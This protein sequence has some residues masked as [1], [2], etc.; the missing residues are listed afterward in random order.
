MGTRLSVTGA[1]VGSI[2]SKTNYQMAAPLPPNP[3][4]FLFSSVCV[5]YSYRATNNNIYPLDF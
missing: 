1:N 2:G 5:F 4:A 3:P